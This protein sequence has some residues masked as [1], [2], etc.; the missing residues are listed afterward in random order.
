MPALGSFQRLISVSFTA[1]DLFIFLV[2][3]RERF[4]SY[5]HPFSWTVPGSAAGILSASSSRRGYPRASLTHRTGAPTAES[6]AERLCVK[7]CVLV[8]CPLTN[9]HN[10][11]ASNKRHSVFRRRQK[12]KC[13]MLVGR[14]PRRFWGSPGCLFQDVTLHSLCL[15]LPGVLPWAQFLACLLRGHLP[16]GPG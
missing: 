3:G 1:F 10:R 4:A 11:G 16:L 12:C 8:S 6:G 9:Y 14:C 15:C 5:M 7:P 2:P 13:K